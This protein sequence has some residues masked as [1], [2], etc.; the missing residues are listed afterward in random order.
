MIFGKINIRVPL[1]PI[2]IRQ[3]W[4]YSLANVQN[5]KNAMIIH[6][7]DNFQNKIEKV[8]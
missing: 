8:Q 7:K 2:Y 3:V 5:I 4:D 6:L 1:P